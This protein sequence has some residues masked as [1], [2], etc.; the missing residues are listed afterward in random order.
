M[1]AFRD[2]SFVSMQDKDSSKTAQSG[3]TSQDL[4]IRFR[5]F[6][7]Y[8]QKHPCHTMTLGL[9]T[10]IKICNLPRV[11]II[12]SLLPILALTPIPTSH[13]LQLIP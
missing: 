5:A 3:Y 11:I 9:E 1:L 6:P 4:H 7:I 8:F 2:V 12:Q 10:L 13:P